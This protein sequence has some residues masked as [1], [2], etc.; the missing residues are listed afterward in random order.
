MA[1]IE[2][3]KREI[4]KT[5]YPLEIQISSLLDKKWE[6]VQN[7]S[8]YFDRE[9]GKLRD[10][11][12][13]ACNI[14]LPPVKPPLF[15]CFGLAIECKRSE[16]FAWVFFTR[17]FTYDKSSISGQVMDSIQFFGKNAEDNQVTDI[18]LDKANLH[19]QN[20]KRVAVAY[21][22]FNV[23]EKNTA[24]RNNK[25]KHE[26]FEAQNQLKKYIDCEFDKSAKSNLKLRACGTF[27]YFP[28]IVF[29]GSLYEAIVEGNDLQLKEVQHI[30]LTS[31]YRSPYSVFEKPILIDIVHRNYFEK[32]L[33]I[34][35]KDEESL[36][37]S[38]L[39]NLNEIIQ[40]TQKIIGS[41]GASWSKM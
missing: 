8:S 39:S 29:D 26:I 15:L 13:L 12:I 25:H 14:F 27:V 16:N 28:C 23:S 17:P 35:E 37:K 19:Y 34:I 36:K 9:E 18:I 38:V 10:I 31:T 22:E 21:S 4:K 1:Q 3:L 40:E 2:H 41:S 24:E 20:S 30:I 6:N 7:T 11:D 5:G 32:Y 33:E